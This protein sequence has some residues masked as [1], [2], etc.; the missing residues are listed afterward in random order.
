MP[1]AYTHY[2]FGNDVLKCLPQ[3]YRNAVRKHK[4]LYNIGLHGPDILFYYHFLSSNPVNRLGFGMHDRSASEFFEKM[5]KKWKKAEDQDALRAYLYGFICH[6]SLD[7]VCHPYIE[8]MLQEG[9]LD[10]NEL[11]TELDRYFMQKDGRDISKYIPIRHIHASDRNASVIASCFPVVKPSEIRTALKEMI[12]VHKL[13][14]ISSNHKRKFLN[15]VFKVS[16]KYSSYHGLV[17]KKEPDE[18]CQKYCERL[19]ALYQEAV[20]V[21]VSLIG[22]YAE[23]LEQDEPLSSRFDLTFGAGSDWQQLSV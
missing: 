2:R 3:K 1:A 11:E 4:E 19:D 18:I 21:A 16:G 5:A 12:L 22:Q 23:V 9:G 8:K 10:H 17:M 20:T 6:F 13:L 7:S 15:A 14:H